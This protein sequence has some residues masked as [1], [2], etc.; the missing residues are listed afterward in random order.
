M[1][2]PE[3][4]VLEDG[5]EEVH[6]GLVD[7]ATETAVFIA[8]EGKEGGEHGDAPRT[9]LLGERDGGILA[10]RSK[11]VDSEDVTDVLGPDVGDVDVAPNWDDHVA[12]DSARVELGAKLARPH[13]GG[14]QGG[15]C[16][17]G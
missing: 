6:A 1:A 4:G 8:G 12:D 13:R 3:G 17:P 11:L 16:E 15:F 9:G 10:L 14:R 5:L 7:V 2:G